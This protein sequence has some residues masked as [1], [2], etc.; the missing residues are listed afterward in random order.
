MIPQVGEPDEDDCEE[1]DEKEEEALDFG[2][3]A[4]KT[5]PIFTRE[6][7]GYKIENSGGKSGGAA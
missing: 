4:R 3:M 2:R 7:G 1:C 6:A 5:M